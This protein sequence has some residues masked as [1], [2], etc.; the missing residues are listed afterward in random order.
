MEFWGGLLN[1]LIMAMADRYWHCATWKTI[2]I[3]NLEKGTN[4]GGQYISLDLN[5]S[6]LMYLRDIQVLW[7]SR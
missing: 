3:G 4:I 2:N 1:C 5:I 6:G 7:S